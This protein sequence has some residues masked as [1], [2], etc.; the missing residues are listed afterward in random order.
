M[1]EGNTIVTDRASHINFK[2]KP[3]KVTKQQALTTKYNLQKLVG[4]TNQQP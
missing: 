3:S 4:F 2:I 1:D